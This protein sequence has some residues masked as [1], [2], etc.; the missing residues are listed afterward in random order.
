MPVLRAKRANL[1]AKTH[2]S[3][4]KSWCVNIGTKA[5]GKADVRNFSTRKEAENFYNEWNLKLVQQSPHGL[6]DLNAIQR[7]EILAAVKKLEAF[8]AS[9]PEAVDFFLKF[10]RPDKGEITTAEAVKLFLEKKAKAKCSAAYL[11]SCSKTYFGPFAKA[12]PNRVVSEITAQEVEK[13]V[14]SH[15]SWNSVTTKS[16][17]NYLSTLFAFLIKQRH[18]KLNPLDSLDRPKKARASAKTLTVDDVEKLLQFALDKDCKAEC[19]AMVLVFFCAVR[20]EEVSRLTWGEINFETGI[21][22]LEIAAAKTG[23]RRVNPI[24]PNA[25]EWLK[26]CKSSCNVAPDNYAKRMQRLR[27]KAAI[28]YPQN[29]MRHC[30]AGYHLALHEDAPKTAFLLGHPN[31]KLLYETY[32]EIVPKSEAARYWEIIPKEV[33][34]AREQVRLA[35]EKEMSDREKTAAE[36][37][38]NCNRAEFVDGKWIPVTRVDDEDFSEADAA[39]RTFFAASQSREQKKQKR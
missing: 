30:F 12:F 31:S 29:A 6:S 8:N 36:E 20:V 32:Y 4:N 37:Q 28:K 7:H 11:N 21:V 18:A 5:D 2:R 22:N 17:I 1:Y 26:L 9:I 16:H 10:S 34:A 24:P 15:K 3:G 27:K 33:A 23:K 14:H 13:Y 38:S 25:L 35:Q 39:E 19:A